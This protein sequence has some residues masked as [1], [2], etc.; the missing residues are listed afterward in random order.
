M[1]GQVRNHLWELRWRVHLLIKN[2]VL[3]LT[4]YVLGSFG[5]CCV[6]ILTSGNVVENCSYIQSR[7]FPS[8]LTDLSAQSFAIQKSS[9]GESILCQEHALPTVQ[10]RHSS[11]TD[12]S[13]C[14]Y[15]G[16][17]LGQLYIHVKTYTLA[18]IE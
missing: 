18:I 16:S 4:P 2:V 1:L 15:V 17:V 8:T 13:V 9:S 3:K 10:Y 7:G 11:F 12:M 14:T 5:V 6:F